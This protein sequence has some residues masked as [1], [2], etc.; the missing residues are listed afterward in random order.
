M[1]Q[2]QALAKEIGAKYGEC[3]AKENTGVKEVIRLVAQ[4]AI[5]PKKLIRRKK[6]RSCQIL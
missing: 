3:S 4:T 6:M 2:G 1:A 5:K